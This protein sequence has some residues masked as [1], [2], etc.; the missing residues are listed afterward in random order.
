MELDDDGNSVRSGSSGSRRT[1]EFDDDDRSTRSSASRRT[2][3]FDDDDRSM[4]SSR[5]RR[6]P[7]NS[8][9]NTP[10]S[11]KYQDEDK[12]EDDRRSMRSSARKRPDRRFDD[13]DDRRSTRS[14][15]RRRDTEPSSSS[16]RRVADDGI[17]KYKEKGRD[18]GTKKVYIAGDFAGSLSQPKSRK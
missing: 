16:S 12:F 14:S 3:E 18:Q 15:M 10:S 2:A 7:E 5:D 8:S 11:S 9:R 13:Q 6:G 1:A 4:K 17:Q